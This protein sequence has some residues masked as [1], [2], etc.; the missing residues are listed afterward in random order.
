[1]PQFERPL[2]IE[3]MDQYP[4][5]G[6]L[7]VEVGVIE[8]INACSDAEFDE[9]VDEIR[10][11][12][13]QNAIAIPPPPGLRPMNDKELDKMFAK[14]KEEDNIVKQLP[15]RRNVKRTNKKSD[16]DE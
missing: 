14:P 15:K 8:F 3:S 6:S 12:D 10:K 11:I 16:N 7:W 5:I 4:S 13:A 2:K 9:L 1:M